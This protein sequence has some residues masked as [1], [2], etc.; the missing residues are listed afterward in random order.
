MIN[1]IKIREETSNDINLITEIT[2]SAF[3]NHPYSNHTEHLIVKELRKHN[4]LSI[5]LVAEKEELLI[6]HIA[7]SP[8]EISDGTKNWYGLAPVSVKPEFQNQGVGKKLIREGLKILEQKNADGCVV[9]GEPEYY[10]KFGFKNNSNI[11]LME[12][13]QEFFLSLNFGTSTPKGQVKY[14]PAFSV[15][16]ED[17]RF[18]V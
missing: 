12:V 17:D 10:Q 2:K 7:F 18:Y 3:K 16:S 4:C 5:S 9:L 15:T 13:S 8:V 14:H 6:G 11:Q 1:F